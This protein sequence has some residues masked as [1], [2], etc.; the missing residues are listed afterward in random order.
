MLGRDGKD[1]VLQ[2]QRV[3]VLVAIQVSQD[4][5]RIALP[6]SEIRGAKRSTSP[7]RP[8][9][10]QK[11]LKASTRGSQIFFTLKKRLN[12]GRVFKCLKMRFKSLQGSVCEMKSAAKE[13]LRY[14]V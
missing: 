2:V 3:P 14:A 10:K 4:C 9:R 13:D 8:G 6:A 7:A 5:V 12:C 1:H 11:V